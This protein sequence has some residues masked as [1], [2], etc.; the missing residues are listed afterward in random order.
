[1]EHVKCITVILIVVVY[2]A[3]GNRWKLEP[4]LINRIHLMIATQQIPRDRMATK[5][6]ERERECEKCWNSENLYRL[7]EFERLD[8][9]IMW[10]WRGECLN[11]RMNADH[12]SLS[13]WK[14]HAIPSETWLHHM[15][16]FT[17]LHFIKIA[18]NANA[19]ASK[20]CCCWFRFRFTSDTVQGNFHHEFYI[21]THVFRTNK[22]WH[23][24]SARYYRI[25]CAKMCA[26]T[27][28]V[29]R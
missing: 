29:K 9:F 5:D 8:E 24:K 13:K 2:I 25:R 6:R 17:Y 20:C 23:M 16:S 14:L 19:S 4:T 12:E 15:R 28:R 18:S 22:R 1:M 10:M 11:E 26:I 3:F 27:N 21:N 7:P